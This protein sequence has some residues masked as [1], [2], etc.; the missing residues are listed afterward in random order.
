MEVILALFLLIIA[1]VAV[2]LLIYLIPTLQQMRKTAAVAERTLTDLD[3][4]LIPLIHQAKKTIEEIDQITAGV[5]EQISIFETVIADFRSLASRAH[6][7]SSLV[8]DQIEL[9]II[10]L[11]NNINAIKQGINSFVNTLFVRRKEG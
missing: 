1:V 7:I 10:N 2:I 5:R 4:E 9:P 8:C 3:R 6:N 11:L